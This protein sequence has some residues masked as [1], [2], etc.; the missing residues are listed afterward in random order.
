VEVGFLSNAD[1]ARRLETGDHRQRLA[2]AIVAGI[3]A[4][5]D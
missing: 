4:Y 1:E 5:A 3:R 2:D